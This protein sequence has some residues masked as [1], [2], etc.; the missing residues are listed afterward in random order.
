M[1]SESDTKGNSRS[2]Q[3][4]S[5]LTL[6]EVFA[7]QESISYPS[8]LQTGYVYLTTLPEE[9]GRS[10][11]Q[12]CNGDDVLCLTPSPYSLR[13][14]INEYG[15]KPYWMSDDEVVF[16]NQVDQCLYRQ[17]IASSST[18]NGST[19]YD[20]IARNTGPGSAPDFSAPSRISI[21]PTSQ[22]TY[23]YS[24]VHKLS[25]GIFIAIVEVN[26]SQK[27][28]A[29]NLSYIGLIDSKSPD[30]PPT[31][32]H[33]GADFYSNLVL[34]DSGYLAWVE[35]NHPMMPW[36]QNHIFTAQIN[37]DFILSEPREVIVGSEFDYASACQ[38]AFTSC[39]KLL[40]SCDFVCDIDDDPQ[41]RNYWNLFVHDV[42]DNTV[43]RL[44]DEAVEFGYPHWQ[45]GDVRIVPLV[46]SKLLAIGSKPN[47]DGLYLID[48]ANK[49]VKLVYQASSTIQNLA[50]DTN[51]HL[52]AL[53]TALN[54]RLC[55][56]KFTLDG[57]VLRREV[58]KPGADFDHAI[59]EPK[60]IRY[61]CRDGGFS[62]AFYYA[63]IKQFDDQHADDYLPLSTANA[64]PLLLMVHGGPTARA[65]RHF[66][67]QKQFWCS[68]GFAVLDVNHRGSSGY[69]RQYRDALYGHWGELDAS[70]IVDGVQW[71]IE[72]SLADANRI[73]IRGKSAGGYA[74]LRALTEYPEVFCAGACYY[75]IG[76]LA[77]L[78]AVTH[79]FEKHYT[80]RLIGEP[81]D[82]LSAKQP[83]SRYYS[84]SPIHKIDQIQ[85][86]MIIFQGAQ[87]K[88]VPP[89]LAHEMT[90]ALAANGLVY[91]YVEYPDE[92]HGFRDVNNNI[93]AWSRE[94]EFY[95][96]AL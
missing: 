78:A 37:D 20:T 93:D 71:L 88:V 76:N 84:R 42:V 80:D 46:E 40:F 7:S 17:V 5:H 1:I 92:G 15:G 35:W 9:K 61:Q 11:L 62:N 63:P 89:A 70:D 49:A 64:P 72:N 65:Y 53:E 24:D 34:N 22:K 82:A 25:D 91:E 23:M 95:K 8:F 50:T 57:S 73:C 19:A 48:L 31:V 69:G 51:G 41:S 68:K 13:T 14:Q 43:W 36:D 96:R 58:V 32:L 18:A 29:N 86:A 83:N 74:V 55:L 54:S 85:S 27:G 66:D 87:D 59:S 39:S 16:V 6:E 52:L 94:L 60:A 12:W 81:Y 79:K 28:A 26:D 4:R 44:S 77:T 3:L 90:D 75:G 33:S 45:Y 10:V 21:K 47:G 2:L 56:V 30:L 67:A 38:L